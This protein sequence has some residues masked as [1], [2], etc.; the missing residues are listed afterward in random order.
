M[1]A[2]DLAILRELGRDQVAGVGNL[3]PQLSLNEVARRADLPPSTVSQRVRGWEETGFLVRRRVWPHPRLL[4]A[5]L[6]VLSVKAPG[7]TDRPGLVEDLA[8][9]DGVILMLE[10]VEPWLGVMVAHE[11][12]GVL[13]RR[14]RLIERVA[15]VETVDQ[16]VPL[17]WPDEIDPLTDLQWRLVGA[18]F[19]HPEAELHEIADRLGV[20]TR[21]VTRKLDPLI[22][23]RALWSVFELDFRKWT[24]SCMA[25]FL[26]T[27]D[28][29]HPRSGVLDTI[30]DRIPELMFINNS[31]HG[32]RMGP[33][34]WFDLLTPL[35]AAAEI[36]DT[37]RTLAEVD[38]VR[39]V[40]ALI[41]RK[42][43]A[44]DHWFHPRLEQR[45]EAASA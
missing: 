11:D 43:H 20:S 34:T 36:R 28:E 9:V 29:D 24:G 38:G 27:H 26:V 42:I 30:R 14:R 16:V 37:Q 41:P 10:H 4:G 35:P 17:G 15:G 7:L 3:D 40:E 31:V 13:D 45:V 23:S 22:E 19:E 32:P 33:P 25:R 8:L 5:Q 44:V 18:L 21:T 12:E 1:D 39:D 6:A 2:V